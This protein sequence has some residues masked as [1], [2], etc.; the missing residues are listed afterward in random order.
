MTCLT[1]SHNVYSK[2][3]IIEIIKL[4]QNQNEA[5]L[6]RDITALIVPSIKSLYS[7]NRINQFKHFTNE[8]NT[9]WH[10]SWVLIAPWPKLDL[11]V[12][13]LSSTFIM[14]ENEKLT[15]KRGGL[16]IL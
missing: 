15:N 1:I 13:F 5:M 3:K 9:Q 16:D 4:C 7:K 14:A 12:G 11:T 8:V 10:E 6:N 2:A